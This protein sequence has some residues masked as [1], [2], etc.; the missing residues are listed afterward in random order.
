MER[1][2][3]EEKRGVISSVMRLH[4]FLQGKTKKR[5]GLH[6]PRSLFVLAK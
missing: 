5:K 4:L 6:S 2:K 3:R 1:G